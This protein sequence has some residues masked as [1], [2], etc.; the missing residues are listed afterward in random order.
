MLLAVAVDAVAGGSAEKNKTF[1]SRIE[2]RQKEMNEEIDV[3]SEYAR[4][5]LWKASC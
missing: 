3:A 2:R 5:I 4:A 1:H